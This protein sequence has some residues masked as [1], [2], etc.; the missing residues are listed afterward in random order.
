[1]FLLNTAVD[2][3]IFFSPPLFLDMKRTKGT[4]AA[5]KHASETQ[6]AFFSNPENRLKR[7]I[8]MKG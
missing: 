3:G 2:L 8:A 1:V 6:K 4:A 5:R 7:S